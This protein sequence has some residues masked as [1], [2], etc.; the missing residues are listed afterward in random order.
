MYCLTVLEV[1]IRVSAGPCSL[2]K[3]EGRTFFRLSP[4]FGM[5]LD[6]WQP[7]SSPHMALITYFRVCVPLC[8]NVPF[9]KVTGIL[10]QG[11]TLLQHDLIFP[12]K[13]QLFSHDRLF[14]TPW[15]VTHQAPLSMVFSSKNTGVG[16][17][18]LLQEIFLTQGLNLGLLDCRR[19]LLP[20]ELPGKSMS[21]SY[22]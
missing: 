8:A 1:T 22:I 18:F 3:Q 16:S 21:S 7:N 20:S 5:F 14:A 11:S 15:T 4:S 12:V 6:L 10:G 17:P 9:Y 13:C 19:T 2:C